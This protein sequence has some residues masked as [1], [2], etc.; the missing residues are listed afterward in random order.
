FEVGEGGER[1]V[2]DVVVVAG[3]QRTA[4][5][6]Q[7]GVWAI[8]ACS[9]GC[10]VTYDFAL[11]AAGVAS[12]ER[13][14]AEVHGD[15]VE[16]PPSVWLLRPAAAPVGS[17]FRF[18]VTSA[19]GESFATGVFPVAG[20]ADTYEGR[21]VEPFDLPYAVFGPI[22]R[23]QYARGQL[24]VAY[25]PGTFRDEPAVATWLERSASVVE[26]YYGRPPVPRLLVV[27]RAVPGGQIGFGSTMGM[28]GAAI[29]MAIGQDI[30]AATMRDDWVLVHEMIHTALPDVT[31]R[32]HWLEEGL[33]TYVESLARSRAGLVSPERMWK[34]WM[35]G[36]PKG[37]P[38]AGDLGLDRTH[39]WGRTYWGGALFCFAADVE[40][41]TRTDNRRSLDDA[42]RAVLAE[43][44]NI[45]VSWPVERVLEVGDRATG[46]TVLRELYDRMAPRSERVDLEGMWRRLGV[47]RQGERVVFD[48]AAP[49]ARLRLAMMT[50]TAR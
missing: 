35:D 12:G 4:V 39:T 43:G 22:R 27:L 17:R 28:S 3:E 29:D 1:F 10:V 2:R 50:P 34:D 23:V 33:A 5:A 46:V 24:E 49:L 14:V 38:A 11:R 37:Q 25:L 20:A 31:R 47:A 32:H 26:A 7:R 21:T 40:I 19:P 42:L 48:D 36:M 44:G 15:A 18:H 30:T 41:R 8:P 6:G 9:E 45:S 16:A 13:S